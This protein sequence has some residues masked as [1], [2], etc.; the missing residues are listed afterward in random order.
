MRWVIVGTLVTCAGLIIW[1]FRMG[2]TTGLMMIVSVVAVVVF[3]GMPV[4][5]AA[6]TRQDK[7]K[8]TTDTRERIV[9]KKTSDKTTRVP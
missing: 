8:A 7:T 4:V 6:A 2:G 1:G 5:F 9:V 3:G